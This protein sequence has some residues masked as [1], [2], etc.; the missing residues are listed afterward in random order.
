MKILH[1]AF[2]LLATG[3]LYT[4]QAKAQ[5]ETLLKAERIKEDKLPPEVLAAYQR[6]DIERW[7]KVVKSAGIKPE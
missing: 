1:I 7:T 3:A 6:S 5:E 2:A 4:P